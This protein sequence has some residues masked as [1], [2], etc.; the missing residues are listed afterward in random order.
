MNEELRAALFALL[1]SIRQNERDEEAGN[2]A[3]VELALIS[4][5]EILYERLSDLLLE[6]GEAPLRPLAD[7]PRADW[8]IATMNKIAEEVLA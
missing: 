1:A 8:Q 5:S 2:S 7:A 4:G 3:E 6:H